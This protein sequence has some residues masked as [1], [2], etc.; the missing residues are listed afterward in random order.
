MRVLA[1]ALLLPLLAPSA[2]AANADPQ[3]VELHFLPRPGDKLRQ[4]ID[5]KMQ[6]AMNMLPGAN[7]NEADRAKVIEGLKKMPKGI[8]MDMGMNMRVEASE[9]DAKGDYLLHVR[10][11]DG[12]M[13]MKVGDEPA[14]QMPNV[15]GGVEID[16]LTNQTTGGFQILRVKSNMPALR[17]PKVMETIAQ[18]VLKEAF[19]AMA[20]L[21]GRH[22]K[23]GDTAEIPFDLRMP[24]QQLPQN[25]HVQASIVLTL[26][27]IEHG[28]AHFDSTL[29]MTMEMAP[30]TDPGKNLKVELSGSGKGTMDYRVADRLPLRQDMEIIAHVNTQL[31][32]QVTMQMDMQMQMK[33]RAER[34][35]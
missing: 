2:H 24:M 6:M 32:T 13:Q 28:I 26:R 7:T 9:T 31:P 15:M 5:M 21:E 17:D 20:P 14:K 23:I 25:A 3:S 11:E 34:F 18:G 10:G 29:K 4:S 22:M 33:T 8:H 16:A 12:R 1:L 30:G 27:S 35:H 19:G